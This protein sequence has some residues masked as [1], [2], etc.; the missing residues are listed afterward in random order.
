M[1]ADLAA[2]HSFPGEVAGLSGLPGS[3]RRPS[4][5]AIL[6][7]VLV[8][9]H[10]PTAGGRVLAAVATPSVWPWQSNWPGR[11]PTESWGWGIRYSGS[12]IED[13]VRS[14]LRFGPRPQTP[15]RV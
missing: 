11:G 10:A 13:P 12:G 4:P 3:G 2:G 15:L 1:I 7:Y 5:A 14:S 8:C 9:G 6:W